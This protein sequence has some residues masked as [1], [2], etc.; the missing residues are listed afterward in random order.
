MTGRHAHSDDVVI[1]LDHQE[2]FRI[3]ELDGL[4]IAQRL[5]SVRFADCCE[6]PIDARIVHPTTVDRNPTSGDRPSDFGA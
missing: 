5:E 6:K 1:L 4:G 2:P 3:A